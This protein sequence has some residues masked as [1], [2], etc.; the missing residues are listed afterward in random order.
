MRVR[1]A[2]EIA[3]LSLVTAFL[4][5]CGTSGN[6]TGHLDRSQFQPNLKTWSLPLDS[7]VVDHRR[8][9]LAQS[10]LYSSCMAAHGTE[11]PIYNLTD[12][13]PPTRN[14]VLR[15][16]FDLDFASRY[17]YHSGPVK[18]ASVPSKQPLSAPVQ[19]QAEACTHSSVAQLDG[20]NHS[21]EFIGGLAFNAENA[22]QADLEVRA[23]IASW[24]KCMLPVG[25]PDLPASP[26]GMPS[27]SQRKAFGMDGPD[28]P[29]PGYKPTLG[30][31]APEEIRQATADARCRTSSGYSKTYYQVEVQK[32]FDLMDKAPDKLAQAL[33][34]VKTAS[35]LIA[36][37]LRQHGR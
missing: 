11:V 14:K 32:Q 9:A 22:A 21:S 17:G 28:N 31:A 27:P 4:A 34:A 10:I 6:Q 24:R 12:S 35:R 19:R 15:N 37:V 1:I 20:Y 16:L 3:S 7:Y 2:V 33:S 29:G 8:F 36:N 26:E 30:Q 13:L 25:V 5:S 23:R 18:D